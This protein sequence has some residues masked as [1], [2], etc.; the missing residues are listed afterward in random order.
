VNKYAPAVECLR[1]GG[2]IAYPTEAVYGLGCDPENSDA[3]HKILRLKQRPVEKGLILIAADAAQLARYI[4]PATLK[5]Y[6]QVQASWPGPHTWILPCTAAT[7]D[8]LTGEHDALAVRVTDHPIA[9]DL[10]KAFGAPLVSTSANP[11]GAD[12]ARTSEGVEQYFGREI[13]LIVDGKVGGLQQVSTI[14]DARDGR[15]VR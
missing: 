4:A 9:A 14:R 5:L 12:P 2:V 10:C 15:H 1:S 11:A 8:W 13:D 7:P 6:P 3:V